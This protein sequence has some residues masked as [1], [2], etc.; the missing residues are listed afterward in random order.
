M[1]SE[2]L[3]PGPKGH[4]IDPKRITLRIYPN[5]AGAPTWD[6]EGGVAS[7][8][9][10]SAGKFLV[11]LLEGYYKLIQAQATIQLSADNVDLLPQLGDFNNVNV[12]GTQVGTAGQPVTF[13]VKMKTGAVNTDVAAATQTIVHVDVLFEDTNRGSEELAPD[14]AGH[15]ERQVRRGRARRRRGRG[16]GR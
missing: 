16:H 2:K 8:A 4:A 12:N 14:R 9:Y 13:N 6:A 10:V 5:G 7:V 3:H 11:T 15:A 1:A